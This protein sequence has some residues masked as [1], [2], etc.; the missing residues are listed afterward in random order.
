[1]FGVFFSPK[2]RE[3]QEF[4]PWHCYKTA[5]RRAQGSPIVEAI[6]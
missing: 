3:I 4:S 1:M 6:D 2:K 5:K